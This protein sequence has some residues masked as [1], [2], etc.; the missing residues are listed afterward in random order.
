MIYKYLIEIKSRFFFAFIAWSFTTINC[1]FFKETLLFIIIQPSF[2]YNENNSF[3]FLTTNVTEIFLT[4]IHLS[5]FITNQILVTFLL[6]Q[7]FVFIAPGLYLYEYCSLRTFLIIIFICW[8]ILIT[9]FN[10]YI[11]PTTLYFFLEFQKYLNFQKSTFYFEA[12]LNEYLNFYESLYL[13]CIFCFQ[14]V[15]FIFLLHI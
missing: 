1:Y 8:L 14:T 7:I 2:I 9:F 6:Y 13:L 10:N 15:F 12:K 5:Y 4:Y 11:F 3:Y